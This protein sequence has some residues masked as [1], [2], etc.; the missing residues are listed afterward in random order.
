MRKHLQIV[1]AGS[2]LSFS[3]GLAPAAFSAE[4][5]LVKLK[6]WAKSPEFVYLASDAEKKE[7]K[8]VTS[9]AEAEKLIAL[10]WARRDPD[11][12]T[13][14]NEFK[15]RFDALVELADKRFTLANQTRGALTERGKLY[16]LLGPP[17]NVSVALGTK[18]QAPGQKIGSD[19]F[20]PGENEPGTSLGEDITT[21]TY[22]APQLPDWAGTKALV[23]TFAVEQT[24]DSLIGPGDVRRIEKT[25]V[26]LALKSPELK[27]VPLPGGTV[28]TTAVA[29]KPGAPPAPVV[30][31][32][33]TEALDAALAKE[34][35]GALTALPVAYRDGGVRLMLQVYL[36]GA[37][38]PA[39]VA[40][41]IRG[42]DGHEVTRTEEAADAKKALK[43]V[44]VDRA[45]PLG[46]GDY[47]VA[48]VLLDDAGAVIHAAHR[49]VTVPAPGQELMA[50]PLFLAIADL[51]AD[52]ASTDSPFVFGGRK[53]V[54]RG[55]VRI[56][57]TDGLSYLVRLSGPGVDPATKKA[58]LKRKIKI[59]PKGRAAMELPVPPDEPVAVAA[60]PEGSTPVV[61]MAGTVTES[62]LGEYFPPGDYV[63]K[64]SVEDTVR[65]TTLDVSAPFTI[66]P[67]EK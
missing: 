46:A 40:W 50:S 10:F 28:K 32:A 8:K 56:K 20:N 48:I 62:N 64:I 59:Q 43:G 39:R 27:E 1:A 22:E 21:F 24:R 16:I 30:S 17:K 63:F 41:A 33:A 42:K 55:D 36:E 14:P 26:K 31:A 2:L 60:G 51:P 19:S 61:D 44:V 3:A 18:A 35:A 9:D 45:L 49:G 4:P 66:A 15:Q 12:A 57:G 38:A 34:P 65:K 54:G 67:K 52:G 7:W 5:G 25:A 6:E 13:E 29:A 11:P 47:D 53:F 37:T 23:A 58:F